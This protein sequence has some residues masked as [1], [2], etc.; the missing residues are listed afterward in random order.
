MY[1]NLELYGSYSLIIFEET[2]YRSQKVLYIEII[3]NINKK[4][5]HPFL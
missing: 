3:L 2:K 4:Y 1:Y 5:K